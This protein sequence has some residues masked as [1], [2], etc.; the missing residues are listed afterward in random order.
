MRLSCGMRRKIWKRKLK[1]KDDKKDGRKRNRKVKR[2]QQNGLPYSQSNF[3]L[4]I[5]AITR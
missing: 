2:K 4:R 5:Y 3:V 1:D